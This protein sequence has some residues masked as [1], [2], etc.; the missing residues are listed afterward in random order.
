MTLFERVRD[1]LEPDYDI[2]RE[3][4]SG[5][6]GAVFDAVDRGLA[7]RVAIKVLRPELATAHAVERFRREARALALVD[8]PRVVRVHRAGE[9]DG[10]FYYVME[11]V[12][13]ETLADRLRR[14]RLSPTERDS[15]VSDLIDALAATHETGIV[16]RD[17]KPSNIFLVDQGARLGDFGIVSGTA[18]EKTARITATGQFMGTPA[19]AAPEQR[20]GDATPASD[21]Y[22]A[23]LVLYEAITG[24]PWRERADRPWDG[25]PRGLR[26]P[27]GRALDPEPGRRPAN[28]AVFREEIGRA[29][30]RSRRLR[31]AALVGSVLAV[32]GIVAWITR[33]DPQAP[34]PPGGADLAVVPFEVVGSPS[35]E[36]L[37]RHLWHLTT[38][39]LQ[40]LEGLEIIPSAQAARYSATSA[41]DPPSAAP[42]MS[43]A[44]SIARG[45]VVSQ[46]EGLVLGLSIQDSTGRPLGER[47]VRGSWDDL[48]AAADSAAL[49][50]ITILLPHLASSYR[51]LEA[52]HTDDFTAM[53]A[54]LQGED[55]FTRNEWSRA[56]ERYGTALRED[57]TLALAKW[58][59]WYVH[60]WR[61][62]G[63]EEID[64]QRLSREHADELG[65]VDAALL[66]AKSLPPGPARIEALESVARRLGY[67]SY[68]WLILGDEH[69]HRGP[70]AGGSLEEAATYLAEAAARDPNH[71]PAHEHSVMVLTRLGR[72]DGALEALD[73]LLATAAPPSPSEPLHTPTF[74]AQ[75]VRERFQPD[76][77][78]SYRDRLLDPSDP[79]LQPVLMFVA[80]LGLG[81]DVPEG[82]L[83]LGVR[84]TR[85]GQRT[86]TVQAQ[87][88]RA[89][90]LALLVLGRPRAALA[91]FDSAAALGAPSAAIEAAEWRLLGQVLGVDGIPVVERERA[92]EWLREQVAGG[93]DMAGRAAWALALDAWDRGEPESA[94]AWQRT[95]GGLD[96]E[97]ERWRL[98]P[99]LAAFEALAEGR[100]EEVLAATDPILADQYSPD[101][102]YPFTRAALHLT[103]AQALVAMGDTSRAATERAWA[104]NQDV[105]SQ[106]IGPLQ[107][108]EVDWAASPYSDRQRARLELASA[109]TATACRLLERVHWL[110]AG[111]EPPV[112]SLRADDARLHGRVCP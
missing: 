39:N 34:A 108:V 56:E 57:S 3:L 24:V 30:R 101:Q 14:G 6:M 103:R 102:G 83:D 63:E 52:A 41:G 96:D 79:A 38:L 62:T 80:R 4:G 37:A 17:V 31:A 43:S 97:P 15:L 8:H 111:A 78:A 72:R 44:V 45:T 21:I 84:L 42:G 40:G 112:D 50:I 92:R 68:P 22:A 74:L 85:A 55:A 53:R 81:F 82:Q 9:A 67:S 60:N 70:L 75:A 105:A 87:G 95:L 66:R 10:L 89:Q 23:G 69:Y 13:G 46:G 76:Q 65:T 86:V 1:A 18:D 11:Y 32:V 59:L 51:R 93:T 16:H 104:D 106:L 54:L 88:H 25:V 109:D 94:R 77:A 107:A 2:R 20:S 33:T 91:H 5:G 71:A 12:D 26:R 98:V 58:R 7:Q 27:L 90:A 61:L 100:H 99:L 49:A 35:D 36:E 28:A 64:L 110:W 29:R 73:R 47:R 48:Y 19:Y